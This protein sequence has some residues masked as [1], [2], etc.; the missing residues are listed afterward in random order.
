MG[1]TNDVSVKVKRSEMC[2]KLTACAETTDLIMSCSCEPLNHKPCSGFIRC[3]PKLTQINNV[4][5]LYVIMRSVKIVPVHYETAGPP[6]SRKN[7]GFITDVKIFSQNNV[8][9]CNVCCVV[10]SESPA[11]SVSEELMTSRMKD[12]VS[13]HNA[14]RFIHSSSADQEP[15]EETR[16]VSTCTSFQS[17]FTL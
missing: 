4:R 7:S 2:V 16:L 3:V 6:E 5:D 15:A 11:L 14:L 8:V 1:P 10:R 12:V 17:L 13:A 9:I